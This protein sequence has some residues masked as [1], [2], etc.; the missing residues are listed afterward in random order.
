MDRP[1]PA[2]V[3]STSL[4]CWASQSTANHSENCPRSQRQLDHI[5]LLSHNLALTVAGETVS[6]SGSQ[7]TTCV[8]E[9]CRN[10]TKSLC[11]NTQ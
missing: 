5:A 1:L 10:A 9:L 2:H 6:L 7:D 8:Q 11:T 4:L 3:G